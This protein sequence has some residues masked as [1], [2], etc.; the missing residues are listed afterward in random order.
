[1]AERLAGFLQRE[2]GVSRG[3][4]V[5]LYLQ[6]CPHLALVVLRRAAGRRGGR[7]DQ[8]DERDQEAVVHAARQRRQA[9]RSLAQD[10]YDQVEPLLT[11]GEPRAR[12]RGPPTRTALTSADR[13]RRA[14]IRARAAPAPASTPGAAHATAW[15]DAIACALEPQPAHRATADDLCVMPYTS[16]TTGQPKGC[17][18]THRSVCCTT[19]AGP[20]RTGTHVPRR[21]P[22]DGAAAVPRDRHAEHH[23][24][25]HLL[26]ATMVVL[27]RWDR[28]VAA[29]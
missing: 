12:R 24:R 6:N 13:P 28:D 14:P 21:D 16:G 4:R 8:P 17:M 23:E 1:M 7:P 19:G 2:R 29:A 11:S 15:S 22:A 10:R 5:A 18:H 20:A 9:A 3:D 27:P 25:T 26:G